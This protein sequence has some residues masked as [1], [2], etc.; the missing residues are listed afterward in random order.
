M[1]GRSGLSSD[2]APVSDTSMSNMGEW[3]TPPNCRENGAK[4][5]CAPFPFAFASELI[6]CSVQRVVIV[7]L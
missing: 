5:A 6:E 4:D 2:S 7:L 1:I 3:V